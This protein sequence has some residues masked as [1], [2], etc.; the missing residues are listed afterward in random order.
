MNIFIRKM[1]STNELIER[2]VRRKDN[3]FEFS[4]HFYTICLCLEDFVL[5]ACPSN[6]QSV[7]P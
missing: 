7:A 6:L 2:T 5:S 3:T 4:S 1:T